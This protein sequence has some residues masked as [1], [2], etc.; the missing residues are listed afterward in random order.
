MKE[1]SISTKK[2]ELSEM[3]QEAVRIIE[4]W[5][6]DSKRNHFS[7]QGML[8]QEKQHWLST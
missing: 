4:E 5:F 2:F 6:K 8:E 7:W 1:E 3:Q